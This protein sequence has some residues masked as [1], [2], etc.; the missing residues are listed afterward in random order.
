[1]PVIAVQQTMARKEGMIGKYAAEN[2]NAV[3]M[4]RF[5]ASQDIRESTVRLF[6]KRH[7]LRTRTTQWI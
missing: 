7:L 6:K 1:M 3:A 5:K 2:G 4:Q